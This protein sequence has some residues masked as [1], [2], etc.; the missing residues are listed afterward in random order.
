MCSSLF[1]YKEN[2]GSLHVYRERHICAANILTLQGYDTLH[3][4]N[5]YIAID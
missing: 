4:H 5:K 1:R 3:G 2:I